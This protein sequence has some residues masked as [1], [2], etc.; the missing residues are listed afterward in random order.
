MLFVTHQ[1]FLLLIE[2]FIFIKRVFIFRNNRRIALIKR[3][4]CVR[5]F[6]LRAT[7]VLLFWPSKCIGYFFSLSKMTLG[8]RLTLY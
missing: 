5:S 2:L 4:V 7:D 6:D 3:L 1:L 8:Y